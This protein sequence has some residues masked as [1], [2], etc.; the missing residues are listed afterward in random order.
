MNKIKERLKESGWLDKKKDNSF[1]SFLD[2]LQGVELGILEIEK[3]KKEI[4]N[5][6]TDET[7]RILGIF[8]IDEEYFT[9]V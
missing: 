5:V 6:L 4:L 3:G 8:G 7:K 9:D 1:T 2:I